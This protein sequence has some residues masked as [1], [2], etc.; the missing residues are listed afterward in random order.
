M[1]DTALG[2]CRDC[3]YRNQRGECRHSP[4]QVI[5]KGGVFTQLE[6]L[7]PTVMDDDYCHQYEKATDDPMPYI[8]KKED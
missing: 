7:W 5:A 8:D 6:V 1:S 2:R 4:P 3:R